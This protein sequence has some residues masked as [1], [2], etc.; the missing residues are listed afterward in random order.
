MIPIAIIGKSI[1]WV[2]GHMAV[3]IGYWVWALN[4]GLN[5]QI[6][7]FGD[8]LLSSAPAYSNSNLFEQQY[9]LCDKS[10]S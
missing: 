1:R 4:L 6:V 7:Q 5:T 8:Y 3:A 10:V 2:Y 9:L